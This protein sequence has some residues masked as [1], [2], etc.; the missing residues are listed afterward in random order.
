MTV[1][2]LDEKREAP[3]ASVQAEGVVADDSPSKESGDDSAKKPVEGLP[4]SQEFIRSSI[5]AMHSWL[6][7]YND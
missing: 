5:I 6:C 3:A 1:A 4:V 2:V 7:L